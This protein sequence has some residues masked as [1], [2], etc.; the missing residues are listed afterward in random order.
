MNIV[1]MFLTDEV[2]RFTK[3]MLQGYPF[4]I[5]DPAATYTQPTTF[6]YDM[7]GPYQ[8]YIKAS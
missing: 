6:L 1:L 7:Y 2:P 4:D 5:F 3:Y 8:E